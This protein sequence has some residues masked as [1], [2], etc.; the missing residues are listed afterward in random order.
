METLRR[1][2]VRAEQVDRL[3]APAGLDIGAVTPE[4]I[5]VSILAEIIHTRHGRKTEPESG[6]SGAIP[7]AA[8]E[9][10][11]PVC[12]MTVEVTSA[13]HQSDW[14]GRPVYF[15]CLRCKESFDADP[16]RYAAALAG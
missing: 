7:A 4:E 6:S 2:G 3:K 12:G 15:C 5:A 8:T 9:A 10:R 11:D 14:A 16:R 13:R 1:R